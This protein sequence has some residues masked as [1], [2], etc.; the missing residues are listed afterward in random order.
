MK[1]TFNLVDEA[2]RSF[3]LEP[4]LKP[5]QCRHC[6][7]RGW[8]VGEC[9]PQEVCGACENGLT[10]N[11]AALYAS[12]DVVRKELPLMRCSYVIARQYGGPLT[13]AVLDTIA[14]QTREIYDARID[15]RRHFLKPGHV[16][17]LDTGWHCEFPELEAGGYYKL[18]AKRDLATHN[19]LFFNDGPCTEFIASENLALELPA[20]N[21]I[22]IR[23][24]LDIL[25]PA[26]WRAEPGRV[27]VYNATTLHRGRP[28]MGERP[29]WRYLF[30]ATYFLPGD[31]QGQPENFVGE[32]IEPKRVQP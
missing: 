23:K 16:Q 20:A 27:Y 21:P 5:V 26:S 15:V 11:P 19:Y 2:V 7:G 10:T 13:Q 22:A 1:L 6:E 18:N 30:R 25:E 28:W 12:S 31:P 29:I 24:T 3:P 8:N 17:S 9:H 4:L 14:L 32:Q